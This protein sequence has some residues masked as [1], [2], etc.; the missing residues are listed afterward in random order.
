MKKT[1]LIVLCVLF[2]IFQ[3]AGCGEFGNTLCDHSYSSTV[4]REATYTAEGEMKY[5]C[6]KCGDT[7]TEAIAKLEKHVVPKSVLDSTVSHAKYRV[8]AFSISVG[9]LVN[10]A[11]DSYTMT[12]YSGEEAIEKGYL[13][14]ADSSA[15]VDEMY[16]TVISGET[17]INPEIPYLTAYAEEA[18]IVLMKFNENDQCEEY[19]VQVCDNLHTY[20]IL[21]MTSGY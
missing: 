8:S 9:E 21:T 6:S 3:L 15:N 19:N 18:V 17:R 13:I 10:S 14:V 1:F 4:T 7:Y 2:A 16:C 20:A 12:H 5:V 11:M